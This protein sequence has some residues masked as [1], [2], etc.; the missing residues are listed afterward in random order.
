[1]VANNYV[2][3]DLSSYFFQ[4]K[5]LNN[6]SIIKHCINKSPNK[7]E[8]VVFQMTR[9]LLN[10][11]ATLEEKLLS[12]HRYSILVDYI[13]T[14]FKTNN[15][16][17]KFL[18]RSIITS[19]ISVIQLNF[20]HAETEILSIAACYYFKIFVTNSLPFNSNFF[21]ELLMIVVSSLVPIAKLTSKVSTECIDILRLLIVSNSKHLY[22][23][24][25]ALDPFP[26]DIT[27][28]K[29]AEI[30]ATYE[31]TKYGNEIFT[32]Q[33]EIRHF[34]RV[35]YVLDLCDRTEGLRHLRKELSRKKTELLELYTK[36]N[37]FR[38]NHEPSILHQLICML[39]HLTKSPISDVRHKFSAY[40]LILEKIKYIL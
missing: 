6:V 17:N 37:G 11:K 36:L 38:G 25:S 39:V 32:L 35:G 12:L 3:L 28:Q 18:I 40:Q 8:R 7:L 21:E 1:M 4:S 20:H 34:L 26:T 27:N 9:N 16:M 2:Y 14:Q 29:F 10:T 15:D 33:Q 19:L 30:Q 31:K 5:V 22:S 24:I 23:G 13:I